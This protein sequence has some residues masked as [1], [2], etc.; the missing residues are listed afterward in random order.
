MFFPRLSVAFDR[1]KL[2]FFESLNVLTFNF[3]L[4]VQ[5]TK[6]KQDNFKKS[7][8][9]FLLRESSRPVGTREMLLYSQR[10]KIYC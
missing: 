8:D 5:K 6:A 3:N 4:P 2:F 1:L 9:L 7:E 10:F